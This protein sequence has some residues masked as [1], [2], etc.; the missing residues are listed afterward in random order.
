PVEVTGTGQH[1]VATMHVPAG[2][3]AIFAKAWVL[4]LSGNFVQVDCRLVAGAAQDA[5]RPVVAPNGL[6]V[7]AATLAFNVIHKYTTAGTATV[8]CNAFNTD[9][10]LNQI[11]ITAIKAGKLTNAPMS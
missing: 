2:S 4:N 6:N 1:T 7:S 9:I 3:W 11:K 10:Q 8:E 5:S